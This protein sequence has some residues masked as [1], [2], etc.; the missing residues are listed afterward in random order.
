MSS[1]SDDATQHTTD[2]AP[3]SAAPPPTELLSGTARRE[4]EPPFGP[5]TVAQ[6]G[7][8]APSRGQV[9]AGW[10]GPAVPGYAIEGELGRGG[11]G[12]VYRA[13]HLALKRP[14]A[15]KMI[16]RGGHAGPH[17]RARFRAEAEA[18]ARLQHPN[19]V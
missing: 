13:Q 4:S 7:P 1:P 12:V 9:P 19:I 18:V 8:A 15:L 2:R 10:T 3:A 6:P 11:M 5:A 17:E 16:L 14:V